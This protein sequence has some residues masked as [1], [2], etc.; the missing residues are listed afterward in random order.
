MKIVQNPED[1][2]QQQKAGL[3]H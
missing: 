2:R 1:K 3:V